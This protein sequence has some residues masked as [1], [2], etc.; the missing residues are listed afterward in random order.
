MKAP[1]PLKLKLSSTV[2]RGWTTLIASATDTGGWSYRQTIPFGSTF[3]RWLWRGQEVLSIMIYCRTL[4]QKDKHPVYEVLLVYTSTPR[5][6]LYDKFEIT[7]PEHGQK[8]YTK[9]AERKI[10]AHLKWLFK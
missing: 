2:W 4:D 6:I 8:L 1:L 10:N 3:E 7:I 5:G 9:G